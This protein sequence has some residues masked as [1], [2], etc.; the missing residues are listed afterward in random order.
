MCGICGIISLKKN[1]I[2]NLKKYINIMNEIQIHRGPDFQD[3]WTN[4]Y[5]GLGHSRL[6]IIDLDSR[7]NQ[8][9]LINN[10]VLTFNG[11]IYNFK[12][13][14][15]NI[16][17]WDFHTSSDSEIILAYYNKYG[18]ECLKYFN[19]MF[20]F[21]IWDLNTDTLFCARDRI[22]IKPFYYLIQ[23]DIF[24]FASETKTLIPFLNKI[25]EDYKGLSEYLTFQYYISDH[26]LIKGI[27]ELKPGHS[28]TIKNN[29]IKINKYWNLSYINKL[30]ISEQEHIQNLD[31]LIDE[32]IKIHLESDVPISSYVSGGIDSSIISC[33]GSDKIKDLYHGRFKEYAGFDESIYA[34]SISDHINIDLNISEMN[35]NDFEKYI[36]KIVYHLDLPIAGP[37]SFP[38]YMVSKLVSEKYKVVLGGQGGDEIFAGYVRY[39]IP[40]FESSIE[41]ALNDNGEKLQKIIPHLNIIKNYKPMLENFFKDGLFKPLIERFYKIIDRSNELKDIINWDLLDKGKVLETYTKAFNNQ[42][43]PENDFFNKMLDFDLKYALVGLLQVEDRVSMACSIESRVPLINHKIIEY[44]AKVPEEL[45]VNYGN[46]KYLLKKTKGH[47]LPEDVLYRKDK[48]GFP[49]PLNI[50]IKKELKDFYNKNIESLKKRNLPYLNLKNEDIIKDTNQFSRKNWVLLMFELWY[51]NTFDEFENIKKKYNLMN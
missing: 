45:K 18:E 17:D 51:Q 36:K 3:L 20:S 5:L 33:L 14:R 31:K 30:N 27:K 22:G 13:L 9:L 50:W 38:Q 43:I 41:E 26:T 12:E 46:M 47:L 15:E 44:M 48:M 29:E 39:L 24:Y 34:K 10:L 6:S 11:E 32:S 25:E 28:I 37:G 23:E 8:P 19:G 49:V 21:A 7:S 2:I 1:T 4:D 35:Y 16:E 40:F 42:E